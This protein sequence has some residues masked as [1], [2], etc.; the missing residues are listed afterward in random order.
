MR[1]KA[2]I[3]RNDLEKG[4]QVTQWSSASNFEVRMVA[5]MLLYWTIYEQCVAGCRLAK[6]TSSV[7][8]LET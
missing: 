1:R 4:R 5:E 2:I 8:S 3:T 7:A 6:N